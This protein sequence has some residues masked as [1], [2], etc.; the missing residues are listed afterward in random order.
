[1]INPEL[2]RFIEIEGSQANAARFLGCSEAAVI[3]MRRN[4]NGISKDM[5]KRITDKYPTL[6]LMLL[7]YPSRVA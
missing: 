1:M 7:L 2:E 4:P 5:A 6:D 3:K